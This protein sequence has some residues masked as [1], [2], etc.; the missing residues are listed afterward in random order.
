MP[1]H[2]HTPNYIQ[3]MILCWWELSWLRDHLTSAFG[4]DQVE[5]TAIVLCIYIIVTKTVI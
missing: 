3:A 4:H 2:P 1:I 5:I